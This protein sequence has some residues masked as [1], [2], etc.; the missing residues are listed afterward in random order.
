MKKRSTIS[1]RSADAKRNRTVCNWEQEPD[2]HHEEVDHIDM[3]N[4]NFVYFN[5][6]H[7]VITGN[8]KKTSSNQASIIVPYKVDTGSDGNNA[9]TH[10]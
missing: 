7:L 4:I 6:K 2:Q 5:N 10:T 3:V 1:E 8:L 9:F